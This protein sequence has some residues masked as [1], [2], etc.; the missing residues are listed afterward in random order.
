MVFHPTCIRYP[1]QVHQLRIYKET[2]LP[3]ISFATIPFPPPLFLHTF[4]ITSVCNLIPLYIH[5]DQPTLVLQ[6][7]LSSSSIC[8]LLLSSSSFPLS[9]LA[10]PRPI[11]SLEAT[12]VAMLTVVP[13]GEFAVSILRSVPSRL[14]LPS[15]IL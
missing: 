6:H 11:L 1:G 14:Q 10:L 8:V 12:M 15:N 2:R 5:R 13:Q 9:P 7:T 3:A 4:R